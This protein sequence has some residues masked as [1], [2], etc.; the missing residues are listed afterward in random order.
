MLINGE[1]GVY[2][3]GKGSSNIIGEG[4]MK[5]Y[6]D[7]NDAYIHSCESDDPSRSKGDGKNGKKGKKNSKPKR[8]RV[9]Y[10]RYEASTC[11]QNVAFYVGMQFH[12]KETNEAISNYRIFK[13]YHLMLTKSD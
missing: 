5:N 13:H 6:Q 7:S 9:R 12:D 8:K 4:A 11:P 1:G 3:N 10:L 2:L